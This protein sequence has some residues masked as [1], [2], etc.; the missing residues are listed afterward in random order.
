[1]TDSGEP[2]EIELKLHLTP[3]EVPRLMRHAL[4]RRFSAG[5]TE[6][7]RLVSTYFDT[8]DFRLMQAKV[9]LRVRNDGKRHIQTVKR[10]PSVD[11]GPLVRQEWEREVAA[12][13]PML[14]G[15]GDKKLRKLLSGG[16]IR[17]RLAPQFVTDIQRATWPLKIDDSHV[18]LAVDVG[19]IKG[20]KGSVPVCEVELELKSGAI[21]GVYALARELHKTIPFTL[22]PRSKSQRGFALTAAAMQRPQRAAQLD[23]DGCTL[24]EAFIRIGRNCLL[25]LRA[26]EALVRG[27]EDAEG[28][29]QFRV[30]LRRLRS[31]L[32]AFR[33]LL[34]A[35]ERRSI[36]KE[37][38][39]IAQQFGRAREWDVFDSDVLGELKDRL[40]RDQA[41]ASLS[42]AAN[43]ARTDAYRAVAKTVASPR[44]TEALLRL[45]GWWERSLWTESPDHPWNEDARDYARRTLKRLHRRFYKLGDRLDD[46]DEAQLHQLRLR[47]KKLRYVSEFFRSLFPSKAAKNYIGALSAIQEHLGSL[48]DGVMVKHLLGVLEKESK[49]M[50]KA[51]FARASG[52]I[53][54]WSAAKIKADLKQLPDAWATFADQKPFWK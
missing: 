28:L 50:D 52:L 5:K 22:E 25:H 37:M 30:A 16:K 10:A 36:G 11:E 32:N 29:H 33:D 8:P 45:E 4:L 3:D 40:A 2:R 54:G 38:R 19:E 21:D 34:P 17:G 1:M 24:G 41:L 35:A 31:A 15:V 42:A 18:E 9:A 53:A 7:K 51:A 47:A 23:I 48:N 43:A 13:Q 12:G 46:L 49:T 20:P 6:R 27:A 26:N 39:W 14:K 44:Y